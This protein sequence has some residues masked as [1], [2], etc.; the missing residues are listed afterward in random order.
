MNEKVQVYLSP[1][2]HGKFKKRE[3]FQLSAHQ[4]KA[5]D[6][7]IGKK[8]HV[9]LHMPKHHHAKL[10]RNV[11]ANK[12]FRFN[13][14]N[15]VGGDILGTLYNGIKA[16]AGSV[17]SVI[18]KVGEYIP[19][20]MIRQGVKTG[21]TAAAT[22]AGT[23]IGNP[24]LGLMA[25]P[26]I[27]KGVDYAEK[28]YNYIKDKKAP[29][30]QDLQE[31]FEYF[32]PQMQEYAEE[33]MPALRRGRQMYEE[34]APR[35]RKIYSRVK[36][37]IPPKYRY[38]DEDED[39]EDDE[40][41]YEPPP[42]PRRKSRAAPKQ[43]YSAPGQSDYA[44]YSGRGLK[45]GSP[46]MKAKMAKLRA[47]RKIKG[48]E[49]EDDKYFQSRTPT[50]EEQQAWYNSPSNPYKAMDDKYKAYPLEVGKGYNKAQ[51]D[52]A[53]AAAGNGAGLK[54]G[55]AEAKQW[56]EKMKAMR[57][58]KKVVG[59]MFERTNVDEN[60]LPPA[61]ADLT[62]EQKQLRIELLGKTQ[63]S[64]GNLYLLN[65]HNPNGKNFTADMRY[66]PYYDIRYDRKVYKSGGQG[67]KKKGKKIKGGWNPFNADD[68]DPNKNGVGDVL[69]PT[70]NGLVSGVSAIVNQIGDTLRG[71]A[72]N[73]V[74][75][76]EQAAS[77]TSSAVNESIAEVAKNLPSQ[78]DAAAFGK[79][80]ASEL[81]HRGIPVATAALCSALCEAA[82][83]EGGPIAGQLGAEVGKALGQKL[84]DEVGNQTGYGIKFR[85]GHKVLVRG[86]TL[87][88]GVPYPHYTEQTLERIRTHGLD[89]RHKGKN[90]VHKGGSF[91]PPA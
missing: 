82:F 67:L 24:E 42:P 37:Y 41:Y 65:G 46:E 1:Q 81:I 89:F 5:S 7:D 56:G 23:M 50:S 51:Q 85:R 39:D 80:M 62:D 79:Q 70:K 58:N 91:I 74:S 53:Y 22:A 26:L 72:D 29:T 64:S 31:G 38:D 87:V 47:M 76:Y 66:N 59:G 6:R 48:G 10:M 55:S 44:G 88:H 21:L 17:A 75:F 77:S 33:R 60:G 30:R 43:T 83:P 11:K 73:V 4:L 12:G 14:E 13:S 84:A 34:Y 45:K 19:A 20:D 71:A 90:G 78:A 61:D 32:R 35:A 18:D 15:V 54:K 36:K 27:S 49:M 69:D 2:Q 9:E 40:D 52:A 86:G 3:P 16:A 63:V 68:W 8:F 28:G 57:K 25:A